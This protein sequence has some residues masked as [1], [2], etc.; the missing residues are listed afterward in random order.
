M[1]RLLKTLLSAIACILLACTNAGAQRLAFFNLKVEDGLA[2]SQATC[3]TQDRS[4]NLWIGTFGGLSRFDGRKIR[5][6]S[7][8][9]GLLSNAI[10]SIHFTKSGRLYFCSGG[11][12][13]YFDGTQFKKV[14]TT[15]GKILANVAQIEEDRSGTLFL[16]RNDRQLFRLPQAN[17]TAFAVK[18]LAP[19]T[20]I[21]IA[22]SSLYCAYN[23]GSLHQFRNTNDLKNQT[24][25]PGIAGSFI[26]K[27]FCDSKGRIWCSTTKGVARLNTSQLE[28]FQTRDRVKLEAIAIAI[29][30][31][32]RGNIWLG[33]N[34][35][36]LRF[37]DTSINVVRRKNG[38]TDNI[39]YCL[40]KDAEGNLWMGTDGE[41]IFRYS[42][43]PFV[44]LDE[45]NGLLNK[46]VTGI[47]GD[48]QGRLFFCGYMGKVV[49]YDIG[50]GQSQPLNLKSLS[51]VA[52]Q[53]LLYQEGKGLWI[54]TRGKG[55]IR[56][57]TSEQVYKGPGGIFPTDIYC[58]H[59]S[60]DSTLYAGY[61]GGVLCIKDK[62]ESTISL[63]AESPKCITTAGSDSLF[64]VTNQGLR[65]FVKGVEKPLTMP[66]E[67]RGTD[68]QCIVYSLGK[69]FLGSAEKGVLIY[70]INSGLTRQLN[71]KNGLSSDFIYTLTEDAQHN[72]WAGTGRGICR[73]SVNRDSFKIQV[74]RKGNG[75]IGLENNSNAAYA[76][77]NGRLWFG[78]TEG[79]SCYM[80]SAQPVKSRVQSIVLESVSLL[81]GRSIDKQYYKEK[82][83]WYGI[84]HELC[85][86]YRFNNL[87]F[88]F[89]AVTLSPSENIQYRYTLE[90]SDVHLSEWIDGT[91]INFSSLEPGNYKLKISCKIDGIL[92]AASLEYAFRIKTP[93]HKSIW[94]IVSIIGLAIFTG[95][96][97][98]YAANKRKQKRQEREAILRREEQNKVRE[99]TAEDFHDEVG[100]RLTRI[101]LLANVLKTKL[102]AEHKDAQ[103]ILQQIQDNS[104]QLYAG[105]RDILWSLQTA[106]DNLF[107]ILNHIRDLA[108]ELLSESN[109][110]FSMSGNEESFR[111]IKMPL[112]KS[113]NFIMIW[114]E[115]LSNCV[116]YAEA[117]HVLFQ[118]QRGADNTIM[119]R[120]VDD[121]KGFNRE[122]RSHG[123]GLKNMQAR[124]ARLH[125]NLEI[126]SGDTGT[127]VILIFKES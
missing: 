94:F 55:L 120:L 108:L 112:D 38:L 80:P 119:V 72:I 11:G 32:N 36:T 44:S 99:R 70:N 66:K 46:Q 31:D 79:V 50:T 41:G 91:T 18:E 76:D 33:T 88:T 65:L 114:K 13:Q 15:D 54:A 115:A 42:G 43:G 84:P 75:I 24:I 26:I 81:G 124:A 21:L 90:G 29:G 93:F 105:T 51:D 62:N 116:K 10:V 22:N 78:T 104:L 123:N 107:E 60:A 48:K 77:P 121:G 58:L 126:L 96:S 25:Y 85:L 74:Y 118:I 102:P 86:P 20:S 37:T 16:L 64:L 61:P 12:M 45:A 95:V 100:N 67:L 92:Q 87:S 56:Y 7:V 106:N 97:L 109:I 103:R 127:Q 110:A 98:Q 53:N 34:F 27:I 122:E 17:D 4:G 47:T 35:G 63:S 82:E 111:E 113:R 117:G 19:C 73:I 125:A 1:C 101:N 14:W 49:Q 40:L 52:V 28:L 39:V 2:Q 23:D 6:Y 9:D 59:L 68:I 5:N 3:M 71:T 30:E 83:G 57:H 8:G 69:L 89:Q